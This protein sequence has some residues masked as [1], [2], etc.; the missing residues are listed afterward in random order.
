MEI[1]EYGLKLLDNG[2]SILY[3]KETYSYETDVADSAS[4]VTGLLNATVHL[5]NQ[6]EEYTYVVAMNVRC[7]ILGI[8]E[9]SH[10]TSDSAFIRP[11]EVLIRT[12]LCGATNLILIH[13]H[14][15]QNVHPSNED[16]R[17]FQRMKNA[18]SLVGVSLVDNIII[19]A[20]HYFSFNE[21]DM[22]SG[23]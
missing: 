18:C 4:K 11:R 20:D 21:K 5:G 10:G 8:F 9:I 17:V 14:P 6:A 13:N 15:S 12:L 16:I 19:A 2:Q 1:C 22:I 3:V 7:R 23:E